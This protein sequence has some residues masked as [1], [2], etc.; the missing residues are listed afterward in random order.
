MLS[1][2]SKTCTKFSMIFLICS[3]CLIALIMIGWVSQVY[4]F[5]SLNHFLEVSFVV[6][7]YLCCLLSGLSLIFSIDAHSKLLKRIASFVHFSS[8]YGFFLF[9]ISFMLVERFD[10][11]IAI[12]GYLLLSIWLLKISKQK[13]IMIACFGIPMIIS[14]GFF[15]KLNYDLILSGGRWW[16][17]TF[18]Y[19]IIL[20]ISGLIG[21]ILSTKLNNGKVKWIVLGINYFFAAYF[22]IFIFLH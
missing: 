19:M 12:L 7:Y 4:G 5:I 18:G 21:L 11:L 3:F 2:N 9:F 17:D 10:L 6:V 14:T 22:H 13:W 8:V 20:N 16:W 15:I 1:L